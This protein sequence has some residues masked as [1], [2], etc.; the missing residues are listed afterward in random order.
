MDDAR[1]RRL[2]STREARRVLAAVE[3]SGLTVSAWARQHGYR[4]ETLYRWRHRLEAETA[5]VEVRVK[6]DKPAPR[7]WRYEVRVA[8][9]RVLR[10]GDDFDDATVVRLVLLLEAAAC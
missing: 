7:R 1:D 6:D 4:A 9:G 5:L 2:G 10:V 8:G 3:R